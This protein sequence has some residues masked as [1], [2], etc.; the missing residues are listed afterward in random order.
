MAE[1]KIRLGGMA[2]PNGVL[3]HGPHSW[4]CAIRHEDGRIEV[5]SARKR[6]QASR[7]QNPL[8]RGPVR[9]A[10]A[11]ALLPQIKSEAPGGEAA[12]GVPAHACL[13]ARRGGVRPRRARVG[14]AAGRTGAPGL[15]C[16]DR[17][18]GA[19]RCV[20][21]SSPRT[22]ARSTSRSAPTS[23]AKRATKEH[24]RCGGHLVGP[25][26]ATSAVGNVLAGLAPERHRRQA[27]AAAQI[28]SIA[29][30]TE[31]F[32]WMTRHPEQPA[33]AGAG[34]AGTRAPAPLLDR[35]A[36]RRAARGGRGGARGV[37]RARACRASRL[38]SASPPRSSTSRSR[39]CARGGTPT[40]TST[41]P[42]RRCSP[43]AATRAS[44]SRSSRRT[45]PGSAGWT[46]RSRSSGSAPTS[47]TG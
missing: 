33:R 1:E 26:L 44:S 19:S 6:L 27:Q 25:L 29:A 11:L 21:A 32:G 31:L 22:T 30:A 14:T 40:P 15:G 37:P 20:R 9:L 2:L 34:E 7:I 18:G 46:R 24:E 41:T 47:R 16:L 35:G 39:R 3:V 8:L 38:G 13:D 43:T 28:G 10:E 12:A 36:E 17:A 42:A 4:A 23:T 5:A 45:T